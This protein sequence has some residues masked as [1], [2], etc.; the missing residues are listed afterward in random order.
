M[1]QIAI[2]CV[3]LVFAGCMKSAIPD[4]ETIPDP[5]PYYSTEGDVGFITEILRQ[6]YE[7]AMSANTPL[8]IEQNLST[9]KNY[10]SEYRDAKRL[11]EKTVEAY[12]AYKAKNKE[13]ET[14]ED[15]EELLFNHVVL[16]S[17]EK[18]SYF[19]LGPDDG[20]KK[21]Y[22]TY[23][24]S[25][26]IIRFSRPGSSKDGAIAIIEFSYW[27]GSLGGRSGIEVFKKEDGKW[28]PSGIIG[29]LLAA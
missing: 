11:G 4:W 2:L 23:P 3:L 18:K 7:D 6:R 25:P 21:F 29:P 16:T 22:E 17:K 15:L 19:D 9:S 1:K 24:E 10:V 12:L 8:V 28:K 26:G 13:Q 27:F 20:W 14:V 5:E